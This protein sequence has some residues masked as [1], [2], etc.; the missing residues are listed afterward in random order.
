MVKVQTTLTDLTDL[1]SSQKD[2]KTALAGT[3]DLWIRGQVG[4]WPWPVHLG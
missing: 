4:L 1:S 3:I 2:L